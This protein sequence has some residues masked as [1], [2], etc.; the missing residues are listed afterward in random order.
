MNDLAPVFSSTSYS[1]AISETHVVGTPI[2]VQV[3]AIDPEAGHTVTYFTLANDADSAFFSVDQTTG[4]VCLANSLDSD[5]PT[6]H[7][8]F[9]FR[10]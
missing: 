4:I 5:P 6:S 7:S 9:S 3:S 8:S 10:V 1:A 2:G